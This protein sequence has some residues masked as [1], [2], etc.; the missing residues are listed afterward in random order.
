MII[1]CMIIVRIVEDLKKDHASTARGTE[2]KLQSLFLPQESVV[3]AH[4]KLVIT[5]VELQ[6]MSIH[7]LVKAV[8]NIRSTH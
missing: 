8:T 5:N 3:V 7:F 2:P 6:E 1:S 4:T